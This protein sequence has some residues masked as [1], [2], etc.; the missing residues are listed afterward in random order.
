M[1][2]RGSDVGVR[3]TGQAG[4]RTRSRLILATVLAMFAAGL[5]AFAGSPAVAV[6]ATGDDVAVWQTGNSWTYG[7]TS[8]RYQAEG[9]D[10]T[11]N[12]TVTYSVVG[13]EDFGGHDAYK[14]NISGT[15]TGGSGSVAVDGVGNASLGN[16]GGTVSGTR[17]VRTSDLA[18]LQ[19]NQFQH[20][21]ARATVSIISTNIVADIELHLT[22]NPSWK[23]HDFPLNNGDN[24]HTLTDV[25]YTGG[26]TYDAGSLG[27][28]GASP[29]DGTL[30][31]DAPANTTS[32][33]V[34]AMGNGA[35][36]VKRVFSQ[37]ADASMSDDSYWSPQFK[38]QVKET[39]VLPLDG[40][41]V[42]L[43][44]T[45]TAANT[46]GGTLITATGTPSYTCAGGNV[47]ISGNIVGGSAG[48]T[49]TARVDTSQ[50]SPGSGQTFT[51]VTGSNGAYTVNVTAPSVS[52]G[53]ARGGA[54]PS[55]GNYGV[56]LTGGG[57]IGATTIV[58]SA[59]DCSSIAYTGAIAGPQTG[60]AVV[61]AQLNDLADQA[62][63][64][65]RTVTFTLGGGATVNATTDAAGVASATIPVNAAPRST[66]ISA[67]FAGAA[68]LEAA[69]TSA[70]FTVTTIPT[71]STV[72]ANPG[73]AIL[74]DP[75][76]FTATIAP[77]FG[78]STPAG[79]VQFS[80]D[81]ADF[82]SP[83][84]LSGGSATSAAISTLPLGFHNVVATYL[85]SA[86]HS[87]SASPAVQF[88]VRN[89]LLGTST[90]Q[91]ITPTSSVYGQNVNLAANV[92]K[93][94]GSDPLTGSV[95][96]FDG[97]SILG[98][99]ALDGSGNAELDLTDIPVGSH[100]ITAN[101]SGDDVYAASASAPTATTVAKADTVV[102]L[103]SSDT[104]TVTGE[105]V[106][107]TASVAPVAPGS[108]VP[109]GTA[110]L[111]IDGNNV[112]SPV[113][114]VGGAVAFDPVSDLGA[115]SHTVAVS[116][117]GDANF[118]T[119]SD[120]LTQA[121]A[122]ADTVN[123]VLTGPSPQVE[124]EAVTVTATVAAQSPGSGSP[125][126]TVV[127]FAGGDEIGSAALAPSGGSSQATFTTSFLPVGTHAITAEY[128]G[129]ADYNG[130]T[131][132]AVDQIVI[133]AT[134][135]VA[136]T[137]TVTSSKSPSTFGELVTFT[138]HVEA[139]D[140][141]APLGAVQFSIDG[142]DIGG[143][144]P[145]DANG[146]A[147]SPTVSS[148][149]PGDHLV[150][151][152]FASSA[153]YAASGDTVT[154]QVDSASVTLG[155]TSSHANSNHGQSVDFHATVAS[156]QAGTGTPG[157]F[158]QFRVD[159]VALGGAVAVDGDGEATSPSTT[160]LTPGAHTVTAV[161]SGD[162]HFLGETR[163][164]TQS[165]G[166]IGTSTA[167]AASTTSPTFG[168]TVTLTAT[169]TPG[170]G[171]LGAPTGTVTFIDG[172][173][174]LGTVPLAAVGGNGKATF[175]TAALS[176]GAHPVTAVYNGAD[177]FG[178]STSAVVTVTVAKKAT[179]LV[180][181]AALVRLNPLLGINLGLLKAR[182]STASGPLAG[183]PVVFTIGGVTACTIVTDG[184]GLAVCD[185]DSKLI[186]LILAG[187]YKATY[188]GSGDY[189]GSTSNGALIK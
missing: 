25:R 135:V 167:L 102:D 1:R 157:G 166:V 96:F 124:E 60:T 107:F 183:Q 75:V 22:P 14:L 146:D 8:F 136:T 139:D 162:E 85:G 158:V 84:A 6:Q 44:R 86:D 110:Q 141:S 125:T 99:A 43:N 108:G 24:W 103:Q 126:G 71:T 67:S 18:L 91:V 46:S 120:S 188:P 59:K 3:R 11:I 187:G 154:Q 128:A 76:T 130:S 89:P 153:A 78:G 5:T 35:L 65:G 131:A 98:T 186:Q 172:S 88:R 54:Q 185:A 179:G 70:G 40:G 10:V 53:L 109:S 144:V 177:A 189:V 127:F 112:G 138:A 92:T 101:Y 123:V 69:S 87:G 156:N 20:L 137:T 134:A 105:T 95:T 171:A 19:E 169:V 21:T 12:E 133:A 66:T 148:P 64:A 115:G 173:T 140:D 184:A 80:V 74:G 114:L 49:V 117:S 16:F 159:G 17:Y 31:F 93:V 45:M 23:V 121:V 30:H 2:V 164:L 150:I 143:P 50:V 15:I 7:N 9:T 160:S 56:F 68:D 182:L 163:T 83:I 178:A 168:D 119:D 97:L 37:N 33:T 176:G 116:Y 58:V 77:T 41:A 32:T 152:A 26:F 81:G 82:G 145:V 104:S 165:V 52:D 142:T 149:E 42:T 13:R 129:D 27:G 132:D 161:Y 38:N 34:N 61:S 55:R 100:S 4:R 28:T 174:P 79:S 170:S 62:N 118:R 175:S 155:L 151:A 47:A 51:T 111:V 73:V 94:S 39:L 181:E 113:A 122:K 36:P 90:T 72:V 106:H 48:Q 63:A 147:E 180:A 29:F 57:G